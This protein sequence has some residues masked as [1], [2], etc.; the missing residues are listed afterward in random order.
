MKSY[1]MNIKISLVTTFLIAHKVSFSASNQSIV[2]SFNSPGIP[3]ISIITLCLAIIFFFVKD[4][5]GMTF[6]ANK[7][8]V[9]IALLMI[10]LF[11]WPFKYFIK[12]HKEHNQTESQFKE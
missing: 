2:T 1:P 6:R 11:A 9:L 5:F 4:Y 8:S 3:V 12:Q 7:K 10:S